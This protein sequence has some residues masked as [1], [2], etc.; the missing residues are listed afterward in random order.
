[1]RISE[2]VNNDKP[3]VTEVSVDTVQAAIQQTLQKLEAATLTDK[4]R[5][6]LVSHLKR[7]VG[8]REVKKP[9]SL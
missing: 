4:E 3:T 6:D 9:H 8:W 7:L 2:F 5:I 1:V